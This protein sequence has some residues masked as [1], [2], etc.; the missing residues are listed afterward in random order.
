MCFLKIV[1]ICR[2]VQHVEYR[3]GGTPGN[4]RRAREVWE[5][6]GARL[7]CQTM[8][9]FQVRALQLQVWGCLERP[10]KYDGKEERRR[11]PGVCLRREDRVTFN[12]CSLSWFA[13]QL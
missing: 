3:T 1:S 9:S 8:L 12:V 5:L 2:G 10:R 4:V 11:H 13:G 7:N 6:G